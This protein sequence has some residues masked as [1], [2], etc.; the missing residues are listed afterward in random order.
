MSDIIDGLI[1]RSS[2]GT[3]HAKAM[4]DS[5]PYET[6]RRVALQS[7]ALGRLMRV[8]FTE[9]QAWAL[10]KSGYD[11]IDIWPLG[12]LSFFE[13]VQCNSSPVVLDGAR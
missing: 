4:R 7:A 9:D 8:G 6:A 10:A 5:V 11:V 1:E 12:D 13:P 3:P 2:L